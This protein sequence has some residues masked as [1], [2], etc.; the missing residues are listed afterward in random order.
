MQ[1]FVGYDEDLAHPSGS[2]QI[3]IESFERREAFSA[4]GIIRTRARL[5]LVN[6]HISSLRSS[7]PPPW[8]RHQLDF[9][10]SPQVASRKT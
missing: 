2:G 5:T 9:A 3:Q 1:I 7:F 8:L 10:H 4:I 6:V